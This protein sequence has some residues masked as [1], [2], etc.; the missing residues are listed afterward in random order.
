MD[1]L[2]SSS[3]SGL[4]RRQFRD[5]HSMVSRLDQQL[6]GPPSIPTPR[7]LLGKLLAC[8]A[9]ATKNEE[10]AARIAAEVYRNS[11]LLL[12][13]LARPNSLVSPKHGEGGIVSKAASVPA[14]TTLTGWAAEV[15]QQGVSGDGF[16]QLLTP[17]SVYSQLS[18]RP[19]SIR[20]SLA[21]RSSVKVPTRA[22][23][24][25]LAGPFVL[26][27]APVPMRQAGL[28]TA[29]L[30]RKS[31]KVV[32]MFTREM[33]ETS[34]PDIETLV[35]A[36]MAFD[37]A[38]AIDGVLLGSTAI[39]TTA[40]PG[41]LNGVTPTTATTG[42]GLAA[43]AGDVRALAT[44]IEASGPML[45]PVLIMSAT[46]ELMIDTL[47]M[48]ATDSLP[49]ISS[50]TVPAKQLI[51]IDAGNFAS[52]EGDA[53]SIMTSKEAVI[54]MEDTTPLNIGTA[55]SPATVAAPTSS[56]WQVECVAI[57]L[58]QDATWMMTRTGRVAS[59]TTV[60]W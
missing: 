20:V 5:I 31:A 34:I 56:A 42:G 44:A 38:V 13:A 6:R 36:I 7:A 10:P 60:S 14:Q 49:I 59:I 22:P 47:S 50:P 16:L 24:P 43:F 21:G 55:G 4:L 27:N 17:N 25:T 48:S 41:L 9:L 52:A 23:T 12:E 35:R 40:P 29:S 26:E 8:H 33:L 53:P 19:G 11:P 57:R 28:S 45:D 51:L 46:S 37:T 32:S 54:H 1:D 15:A 3:D 39:S 18:S 30:V 58:T 2:F